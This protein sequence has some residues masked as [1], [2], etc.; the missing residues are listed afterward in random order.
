MTGKLK[1]W[2]ARGRILSDPELKCHNFSLPLDECLES[3]V[4]KVESEEAFLEDTV[5]EL[6]LVRDFNDPRVKGSIP[7][8]RP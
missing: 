1:C 2:T 5:Y 8:K 6:L 3:S 4:R 7:I